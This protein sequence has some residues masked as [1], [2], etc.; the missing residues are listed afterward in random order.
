EQ[1][2]ELWRTSLEHA[3]TSLDRAHTGLDDQYRRSMEGFA[4]SGEAFA[5][6]AARTTSYVE[7][8]PNPAERLAG[9]WDGVRQ[10]ET[11]LIEAIGGSVME[12]GTLR[13]RAEQLRMS[14]ENLGTST[15][16][17]ASQIGSG[18]EKLA[19]SLQRELAQM[20]DII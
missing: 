7:A 10:L 13:E 4:A 6:L 17:T 19:G 3:R 2:L 14:L 16:R 5:E 1:Q 20:N 15:D 12:L 11:D 18:G 9:L 8:L